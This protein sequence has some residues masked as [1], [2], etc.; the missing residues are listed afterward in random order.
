MLFQL[1]LTCF[2]HTM[3]FFNFLCLSANIPPEDLHLWFWQC[4]IYTTFICTLCLFLHSV[5]VSLRSTA[6]LAHSFFLFII[7]IAALN[8][9][10]KVFSN[11]VVKLLSFWEILKLLIQLSEQCSPICFRHFY[12][13]NFDDGIV[14]ICTLH[15]LFTMV[16]SVASLSYAF[17]FTQKR[18]L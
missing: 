1:N 4:F 17:H 18:Y 3:R 9:P 14:V 16:D 7:C 11:P 6:G 13:I 5:Q 8:S 12:L 2:W 10:I 15:D